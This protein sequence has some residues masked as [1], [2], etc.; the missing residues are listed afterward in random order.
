MLLC[1]L[2]R[3]KERSKSP[4]LVTG[5]SATSTTAKAVTTEDNK[6]PI[7]LNV[8]TPVKQAAI[9]VKPTNKRIDMGAAFNYGK[10]DDLGINSPTHKNTHNEDLFSVTKSSNTD[11]YKDIVDDIFS[12]AN[13][14]EEQPVDDFDPRAGETSNF[15]DFETAFGTSVSKPI[16]VLETSKEFA[17]FSSVFSTASGPA[18]KANIPIADNFLFSNIQTSVPSLSNS[19]DLFASNILG[20]N[21]TNVFNSPTKDSKDLLSDFGDMALSS[22]NG[23]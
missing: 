7:S 17:D 6:R 4:E 21:L 23:K 11:N 8:K 10:N 13:M 9:T 14:K 15:G 16:D 1:R 3:D 5:S 19:N 12:S 2:Y 22:T 20:D 18:V